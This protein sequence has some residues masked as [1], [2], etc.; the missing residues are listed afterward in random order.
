[1]SEAEDSQ[2]ASTSA[3]ATCSDRQKFVVFLFSMV[4]PWTQ[5]LRIAQEA[6]TWLYQFN[7]IRIGSQLHLEIDYHFLGTGICGRWRRG[8]DPYELDIMPCSF[9]H[10]AFYMEAGWERLNKQWPQWEGRGSWQFLQVIQKIGRVLPSI[11][12]LRKNTAKWE[13]PT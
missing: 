5:F 11:Q 6:R 7:D 1:M 10:R 12:L 8:L 4:F 2:K 3:D 9:Q 13:V